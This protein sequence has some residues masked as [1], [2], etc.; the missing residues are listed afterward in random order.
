MTDKTGTSPQVRYETPAPHVAR[1]VMARP[2]A[3][4]AQGLPMTYELNAGV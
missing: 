1:I 2:E 4:N 3:H